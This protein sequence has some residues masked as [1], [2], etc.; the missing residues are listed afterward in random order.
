MRR[1]IEGTTLLEA[2][3]SMIILS[4]GLVAIARMQAEVLASNNLAKQRTEAATLAQDVIEEFKDYGQVDTTSGYSAYQDITSG[5]N[6]VT[7]VNAT[8]TLTWTVTENIE[9]NYK[10]VDVN[11][12]W[13]GGTRQAE[14]ITLSTIIASQNP[15]SIASMH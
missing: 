11:V 8:Y 5:T 12:T 6:S 9:P 14:S 4:V 10:T 15:G 3:V 2:M 13:T 7:G 1:F